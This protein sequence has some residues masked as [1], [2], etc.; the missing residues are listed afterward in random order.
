M[1]LRWSLS[2]NI[3]M[4]LSMIPATTAWALY[5]TAYKLSAK[6]SK[7]HIYHFP[8]SLRRWRL[9]LFISCIF[10][11]DME[12]ASNSFCNIFYV[13]CSL[14]VCWIWIMAI[15]FEVLLCTNTWT[16]RRWHKE[17]LDNHQK[18]VKLKHQEKII[19]QQGRSNR[20]LR[21]FVQGVIANW[22]ASSAVWIG[23]RDVKQ[24]RR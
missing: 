5:S 13:P 16:F 17:D 21:W 6:I 15:R 3:Y 10:S 8:F 24:R 14:L 2:K 7:I 4:E 12:N 1:E 9:Q 20:K 22:T 23:P 11:K 18:K 19:A